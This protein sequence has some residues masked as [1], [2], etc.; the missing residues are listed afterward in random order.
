VIL[1]IWILDIWTYTLLLTR[2]HSFMN[3]FTL[4]YEVW[5]TRLPPQYALTNTDQDVLAIYFPLLAF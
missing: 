5:T 1:D 2:L 4:F 3:T